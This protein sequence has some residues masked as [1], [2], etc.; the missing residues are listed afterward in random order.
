MMGKKH[1]IYARKSKTRKYIHSADDGRGYREVYLNGNKLKNCV[2]A[3]VKRGKAW[4][5]KEPVR[6]LPSGEVEL[7][8]LRGKVK[9]VFCGANYGQRID[10]MPAHH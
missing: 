8:I 3:D 9:V 7:A 4:V 1:R 5:V 6:V 10:R 2:K